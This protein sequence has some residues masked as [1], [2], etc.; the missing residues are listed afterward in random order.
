LPTFPYLA[1]LAVKQLVGGA[2]SKLEFAERALDCDP[3]DLG[4]QYVAE[5]RP[6]TGHTRKFVDKLPLNYLY[7]G[8]ISRALPCAKLICVIRD[9][10][11][12]C[13]AMYKTLFT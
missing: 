10:M 2:V 9:P 1:V 8:L 6:Q 12:S 3:L 5:T 13:Y 4:R 11:D 7:A